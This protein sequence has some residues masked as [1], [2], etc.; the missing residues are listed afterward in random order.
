MRNFT[1]KHSCLNFSLTLLLFIVTTAAK[2]I[3]FGPAPTTFSTTD[4]NGTY[5][6]TLTICQAQGM[7]AEIVNMTDYQLVDASGAKVPYAIVVPEMKDEYTVSITVGNVEN[8]PAG[9]YTIK[10]PEAAF[11]LSWMNN[12]TSNAFDVT[13][14]LT[15]GGEIV[16]PDV[17]GTGEV[18]PGTE[19]GVVTF[20]LDDHK[21]DTSL[22]FHE[23][24]ILESNGAGILLKFG[25]VGVD[26]DVY[27]TCYKS[28]GGYVQFKDCQFTISAPSGTKIE[29]IVFVDGA[30][31]STMYDLDNIEAT[32][33]D[34]GVWTGNAESVTFKTKE[35]TY[36]TYDEDEDG[37]EYITGYTTT[38]TGARVAKIYVTLNS[39]PDGIQSITTTADSVAYD[40]AGRRVNAAA[41]GVTIVDGKKVIR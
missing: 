20:T 14:N 32:G 18:D 9:T 41:Q 11:C 25:R 38:V 29:K 5:D 36:E 8:T 7:A 33:Y 24:D 39:N 26:Y 37:N 31:Q 40:L 1:L 3:D 27:T 12:I 4:L 13:L 35:I 30:P 15:N 10:V 16:D 6:V 2:A 23:G 34:E 17:P 19:E 28:N 21:S 22:Y